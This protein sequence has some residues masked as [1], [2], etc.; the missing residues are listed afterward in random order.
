M[1]FVADVDPERFDKFAIANGMNHYSKTSGFCAFKYPEY[2]AGDLVGA[3]DDEGN[4]I[5]TAVMIHKKTSFP[6]GQYSYCQYGFD[7]DY[8]NQELLTFFLKNLKNYAKEKGSFFLRIDPNITRLEHEK[9]GHV[10]ENGFNHEYI[11]DLICGC[12][13]RHLGYNYGYSGNWSNR[14]TYLLDLDRPWKDVLKGIKRCSQYTNK[15]TER[16]LRVH[17]AGIDELNILTADQEV[18]SKTRGFKPYGIE[19]FKRLWKSFEPYIH[20]YVVTANFH[21]AKLN[22][23]KLIH[24]N[25]EHISIMKDEK[26][27]LPLQKSN[28]AMQKE[29]DEIVQDGYDEDKEV[30]LGAKLIIMQGTHVWNVNMYTQKTLMN[31]RAAF[32]LHR[33]VLEDVYKMGAKTYDF[34]GVSGSLDP[35]DI[36]YGMQDFKKSFGG[37][38]LEYLGEFDGVIDEKRYRRWWKSDHLYRR[39]KNKINYYLNRKAAP[40][41]DN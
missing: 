30:P 23:E 29:I 16:T 19:Y 4:L 8:E 10:K 40:H 3:E 12:G 2:Y 28:A 9:D 20:Y 31:F 27:I 17:K 5:A 39:I 11:T 14:Y 38:F 32:A 6:K 37:D 41:S 1:K 18:L 13:Y 7:L 35:H 36:Y 34:E 26:K 21:Q 22:L 24:D 33:Y 15:N 25:Q